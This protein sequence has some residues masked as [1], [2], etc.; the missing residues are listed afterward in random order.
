MRRNYHQYK[1]GDKILANRKENS[2]HELDFMGTLLITEINENFMVLFQ[3]VIIN[4]AA[5]IC[6]IKPF[7]D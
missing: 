2:K 1:V 7:F 4:D 5:N 3:K 6:R